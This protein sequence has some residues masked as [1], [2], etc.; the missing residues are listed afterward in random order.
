MS[1]VYANKVLQNGG[2]GGGKGLDNQRIVIGHFI[3]CQIQGLCFSCLKIL[4]TSKNRFKIKIMLENNS[5]VIYVPPPQS[6]PFYAT[7]LT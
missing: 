3:Y 1:G 2:M 5:H 6:R 7:L 4:P